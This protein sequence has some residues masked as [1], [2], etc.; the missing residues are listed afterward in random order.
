ML[1]H[2][3][4][5]L[6]IF[7]VF[8][9]IYGCA[10][11]PPK[12]VKLIYPLPPEEPRLVYLDSYKGESNFKKRGFLEKV[13]GEPIFSTEIMKPYGVTAYNDKIYVTDT[14]SSVVFVFDLKERKVTFIGREG[15]GRLILPVG[16]AVS[17][18]G[19]VFVS[20]AKQKRVF[21]YDANG[22][23]K[24]ALGKKDEFKNPAGIAVNNELGRLYVV[25]SYGHMV[26]V[27]STKG[28]PLFTFGIRGTQDGEFNYPSNVAIDMRTGNV[29][30]V[31][32]Q[33]F[34]VQVFD[35]DGKSIKRFGQIGDAPGT[36]ARPKG[37]GID[38][39]QHVYVADAAFDNLQIFDE[40]GK[41]LLFIGGPGHEPGY[42]W[43]PAGVYV[44]E[45]DRVYIVDSFNYRVQVFQYLSEKWKKENPEKYN[46]YLRGHY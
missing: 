39:E 1:N 13:L 43:L 44:D 29:Y 3:C 30:I 33:N 23:L 26:H 20:D 27:Y 5:Y 41:I 10:A 25:D 24:I 42:F 32:T 14:Q 31:D 46:E 17:S 8:L 40:N 34:R 9:S 11:P 2:V 45:K 16:V 38:S 6:L 4:R 21:G 7:S 12:E 28:E 36:F 37:I 35:K 19:T 15:M 18:D 22:N